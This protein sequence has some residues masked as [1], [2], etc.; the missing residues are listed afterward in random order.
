M[1]PAN[2]ST[3]L[4]FFH[5]ARSEHTHAVHSET[6]A[7]S[8][9]DGDATLR[10]WGSCYWRV[11]GGR[12]RKK[13][14]REGGREGG[15]ELTPHMFI[16]SR[17]DWAQRT[18]ADELSMEIL[19]QWCQTQELWC[20]ERTSEEA[21]T[22]WQHADVRIKKKKKNYWKNSLPFSTFEHFQVASRKSWWRCSPVC[23]Q[24]SG[25]AASHL[26]SICWPCLTLICVNILQ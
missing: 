20:A 15:R 17:L 6:I 9:L 8:L 23:N 26:L 4:F 1:P 16:F 22:C 12:R 18:R 24:L 3:S 21:C 14:R 11:E 13:R 10:R 25:E 19:T 2:G 7:P 5:E